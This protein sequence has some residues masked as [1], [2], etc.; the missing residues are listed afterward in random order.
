MLDCSPPHTLEELKE[1]FVEMSLVHRRCEAY[2]IWARWLITHHCCTGN[3]ILPE[4]S[5][6]ELLNDIQLIQELIEKGTPK[7]YA[8]RFYIEFCRH[9]EKVRDGEMSDLQRSES[10]CSLVQRE[11]LRKR[12]TGP[13]ALFEV[14]LSRLSYMYDILDGKGLQWAAPPAVFRLLQHIG[15]DTELFASPLNCN[16]THYYSL[17]EYDKLFGSKGNFFS[18]P[19][20]NFREGIYEVNPPFINEIFV[21]STERIIHFLEVAESSG[22]GL[23]FIYIMPGWIDNESFAL[24]NSSKY[25]QQ[26][27]VLEKSDHYYYESST[28]SFIPARFYTHV[29]ILTTDRE[30]VDIP[31]NFDKQL[32]NCFRSCKY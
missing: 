11:K 25:K 2:K 24:I 9:V 4:K 23:T 6:D 29:I 20:T 5:V 14:D 10:R 31:Y 15:C 26:E 22:K 12:Y 32:K 7:K 28:S 21:K 13:D 17:F 18:A 3:N 8:K 1:W 16:L 27:I 30:Q 19:E